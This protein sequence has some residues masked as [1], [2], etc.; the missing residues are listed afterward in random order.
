MLHFSKENRILNLSARRKS[1]VNRI[2]LFSSLKLQR[3]YLRFSKSA[4]VFESSE[5]K[6]NELNYRKSW[7]MIVNT[8]IVIFCANCCIFLTKLIKCSWWKCGKL[9]QSMQ[10]K[11]ENISWFLSTLLSSFSQFLSQ[12]LRL[13]SNSDLW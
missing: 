1:R 8:I 2:Q 13:K 6:F 3:A 5:R 10:N 9:F 7:Q 4:S 11:G 12:N